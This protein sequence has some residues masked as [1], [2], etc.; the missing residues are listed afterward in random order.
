[1]EIRIGVPT[2]RRGARGVGLSMYIQDPNGYVLEIKQDP[3]EP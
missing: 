1:L 2:R 3:D